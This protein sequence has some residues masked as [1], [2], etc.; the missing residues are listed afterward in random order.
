MSQ[1]GKIKH[2]KVNKFLKVV[3]PVNVRDGIRSQAVLPANATR[4]SLVLVE[5]RSLAKVSSNRKVR[6]Q[7]NAFPGMVIIQCRLFP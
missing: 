7:S 4:T 5:A 1:T 2:T 3:Q 6:I